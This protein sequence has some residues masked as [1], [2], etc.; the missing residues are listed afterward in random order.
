MRRSTSDLM[1][2]KQRNLVVPQNL[3][4]LRSKGH[5]Q[6]SPEDLSRSHWKLFCYIVKEDFK[7]YPSTWIPQDLLISISFCLVQGQRRLKDLYPCTRRFLAFFSM[8]DALFYLIL[9]NFIDFYFN[10]ETDYVTTVLLLVIII[11][12]VLNYC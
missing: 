8:L 10:I 9:F 7:D 5:H 3:W 4:S 6:R 11:L 1:A 2:C 12:H